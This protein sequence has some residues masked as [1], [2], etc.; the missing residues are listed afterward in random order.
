MR[1]DDGSWDGTAVGPKTAC[2][3]YTAGSRVLTELS[4]IKRLVN[5]GT[6]C[7]QKA[8]RINYTGKLPEMFKKAGLADIKE[9]TILW[10]S[11]QSPVPCPFLS[12]P[13]TVTRRR[14]RRKLI[15]NHQV[16]PWAKGQRNKEAG[17]LWSKN[18]GPLSSLPKRRQ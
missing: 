18:P 6:E 4:Q 16:N 9:E 8:G 12:F 1:C 7:L 13:T 17:L 15:I 5:T 2:L 14:R 3:I 10:P 11:R